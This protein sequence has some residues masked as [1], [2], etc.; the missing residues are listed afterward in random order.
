MVWSNDDDDEDAVRKAQ[1]SGA[2]QAAKRGRLFKVETTMEMG[3]ND[4][5]DEVKNV[6]WSSDEDEV[7][8][9]GQDNGQ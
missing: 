6:D 1:E 4:E 2:G 8:P 9:F 7:T 3:N 5:Q